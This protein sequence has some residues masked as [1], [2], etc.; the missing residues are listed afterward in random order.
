VRRTT[1]SGGCS[2]A[3]CAMSRSARS[4]ARSGAAPSLLLPLLLGRA[5]DGPCSC[6]CC[7]WG[8]AWDG[9]FRTKAPAAPAMAGGAASL[10][11]PAAIVTSA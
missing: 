1:V 6:C 9:C 7:A 8:S 2:A 11:S 4:A 5:S 10:P 3:S